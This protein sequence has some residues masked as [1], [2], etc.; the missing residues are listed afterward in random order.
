M[1]GQHD[2]T[3]ILDYTGQANTLQPYNPR[4][5]LDNTL[6]RNQPLHQCHTPPYIFTP[7]YDPTMQVQNLDDQTELDK[8]Y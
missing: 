3:T 2:P 6:Q 5:E 7:L 1:P 4:T 8:P